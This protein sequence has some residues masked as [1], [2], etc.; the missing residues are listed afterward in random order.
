MNGPLREDL[1]R[2]LI[3]GRSHSAD[4]AAQLAVFGWDSDT[5]LVSLNRSDALA[6]MERYLCD[7]TSAGAVRE[8]ADAVEGREDIGYE[9]GAEEVLGDL[10]FELANPEIT[11]ALTR[12]VALNWTS[13]LRDA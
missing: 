4:I 7:E 11:R 6:I 10:V 13:R 3:A 1:L 2:E 8:W 5:E 9:R 12:E